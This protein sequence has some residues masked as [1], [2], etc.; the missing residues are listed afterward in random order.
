LRD[1]L[2]SDPGDRTVAEVRQQLMLELLPV[3][4][5]RCGLPGEQFRAAR[6]AKPQIG[7]LL[8]QVCAVEWG[9][10]GEARAAD[11]HAVSGLSPRFGVDPKCFDMG[12]LKVFRA[13]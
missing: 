2:L 3:L 8:V 1:V 5:L 12:A 9:E 6:E 4:L 7:D 10:A 11:R 13:G